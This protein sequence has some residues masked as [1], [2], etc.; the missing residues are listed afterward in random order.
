MYTRYYDILGISE[1][2]TLNEIKAAFREK[3]KEYHP[4]LNL[5]PDAVEKF[6]EINEAYTFLLRLRSS[7][8][9][10]GQHKAPGYDTFYNEWVREERK[11]ARQRAAERAK[12]KF[13]EY[14]KSPIYKTTSTINHMVDSF[15]IVF[16]VFIILAGAFGLY[17]Q[18]LYIIENDKEVLNARGIF[19]EVALAFIGF[20][21][22]SLALASIKKRR[23][24]N[25]SF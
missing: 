17:T 4:D 11:K 25:R 12:M 23:R 21:F 20:L 5:N 1:D 3:A 2:S 6:I 7:F 8:A 9:A 18:G 19:I 16:A 15:I 13:E 14:R 10:G 22:I 24:M